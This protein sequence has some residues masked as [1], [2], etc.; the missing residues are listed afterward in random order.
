MR[1]IIWALVLLPVLVMSLAGCGSS[2][3]GNQ[4]PFIGNPG[5]PV[6]NAIPPFT[7]T[8]LPS[9]SSALANEE[10]IVSATLRDS[11]NAPIANR[12]VNFTISAG[13]ATAVTTS[14]LT[15]SNGVALAFIR[16]GTTNVTTNVIVQ[17]AAN[18]VVGYGSFQVSPADANL[19]ST[20]LSL[21]TT[22]FSVSPNQE[23]V[24]TATAKDG[25]NNPIANKLVTF[26][27]TAGPATMVIGSAV[28][29]S[30][31]QAA[32]IVKAGD[33]AAVANVIVQAVATVNGSD[34]TAVIPFQIVPVT[35]SSVNYKMTMT[36]S[37]QVVDNN[38]EFYVTANLKDSGGN[39]VVNQTVTFNVSDGEATVLTG[40]AVTDSLGTAIA[41]VRAVSTGSTSAVIL[42]ASATVKETIVTAVAPVQITT[43]PLSASIVR[44]TLTSD[45]PTV[46]IGTDV[47]LTATVTDLQAPPK[48]IQATPVYFKVLAGPASIID[49]SGNVVATDAEGMVNT[50]SS[51]TAVFRLRSGTTITGSSIIVQS[52]TRVNDDIDI[53][54]YTTI[55]IVRQN[56]YVIDFVTSKSATDPDGNL[57][58]L[59]GT[60]AAGYVGLVTFKQLVPFEV[61]DNNGN[62]MPGVDVTIDLYNTG[63]N[64]DTVVTLVP[65]LP[66]VPAQTVTIRTDDHGIGIFT[67]NVSLAAPG[68]GLTNTES[69]IYRASASVGGV[70][71]SSYGGF[72]VT[73]KQEKP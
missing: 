31:G 37:K 13:P 54:A 66:A 30:N 62:P 51:G 23:Q 33:S 49:M 32:A 64:P 55:Q 38:E 50:D 19:V 6:G 36:P 44:M 3:S 16:A 12:A 65:P 45:K 7:L 5:G 34:I 46:G 47:L 25:S 8:L 29:D 10:L 20:R 39:P 72:I 21:T 14:A 15:D 28:T 60:V 43:T 58:T 53:I 9:K 52:R 24:V 59:S 1:R 2:S 71:L 67:C 69:I 42:Q 26:S 57:N 70:A 56:S 18:S 4:D 40:L 68:D 61:L 48:P 41:R 17:G 22:S 73:L 27:V 63:R 11:A 35:L